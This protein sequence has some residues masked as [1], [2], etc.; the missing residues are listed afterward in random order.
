MQTGQA[1][2]RL[3]I[4]SAANKSYQRHADA[5]WDIA[6]Y[7]GDVNALRAYPLNGTNTYARA[8][9]RY[10]DLLVAFTQKA[11]DAGALPPE[12]IG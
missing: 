9:K 2:E 7:K 10:R 12:P 3:V 4:S 1:P 11:L 5:L 6:A 8:L